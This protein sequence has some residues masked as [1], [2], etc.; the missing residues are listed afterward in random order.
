ML[1]R[2]ADTC[3]AADGS[4]DDAGFVELWQLWL[5]RAQRLYVQLRRFI[6]EANAD[7]VCSTARTPKQC[8]GPG[9]HPSPIEPWTPPNHYKWLL[10]F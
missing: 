7:Q 8:R 10:W 9:M 1:L 2:G 6:D 3:E 5:C 4:P